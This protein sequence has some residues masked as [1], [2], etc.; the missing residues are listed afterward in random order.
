MSERLKE[1]REVIRCCYKL[2]DTDVDC[3]FKLI[4][5]NKPTTSD[6]LSKIMKVSKTTI[7]NSLKKLIEVGLVE[8]EKNNSDDKRIG[9]PKYY[10]S[11]T[12]DITEKIRNDLINCSKKMQLSF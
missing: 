2:S 3:L 1:A 4:E 6:E 7:E 12:K 5:L 10:Y 8:R 9:R 11:L